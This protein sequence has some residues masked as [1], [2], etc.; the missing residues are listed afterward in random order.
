MMSVGSGKCGELTLRQ[1]P[2]GERDE[3]VGAVVAQDMPIDPMDP[4]KFRHKK[5]P[6][7]SGDVPVPVMHSPPRA[8]P[9][10]TTAPLPPSLS[11]FEVFAHRGPR[12]TRLLAVAAPL[13]RPV[14]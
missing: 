7:A 12:P 8:N 4:P 14:V 10:A 11:S 6:R 9:K 13:A 5:V 2:G 3:E 1:C